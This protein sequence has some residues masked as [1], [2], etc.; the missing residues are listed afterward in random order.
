MRS[1]KSVDKIKLKLPKNF[2]A[3]KRSHQLLLRFQVSEQMDGFYR[4][5]IVSNMV[6]RN[7]SVLGYT[8]DSENILWFTYQNFNEFILWTQRCRRN[9]RIEKFSDPDHKMYRSWRPVTDGEIFSLI[10]H[11]KD[12]LPREWRDL[13]FFEIE[14]N[15]ETAI[16]MNLKSVDK[17]LESA[18]FVIFNPRSDEVLRS[19]TVLKIIGLKLQRYYHLSA[20]F[21]RVKKLSYV[22]DVTGLFNQRFLPIALDREIERALRH[23]AKFSILFLDVD[24]FKAI[25]DT[26]GHLVG[27]QVLRNIGQMIGQL[28]RISDYGFRYGGDEFLILLSGASTENSRLVAE[29]LRSQVE[30]TEFAIDG[31]KINVTVSIGVATYPEH[32]QTREKL[33]GLADV[34][35][36][37]AK[38]R[39]RNTVCVAS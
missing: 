36:Y 10:S 6:D 35:M 12:H 24:Y 7:L 11:F 9:K 16:V 31:H 27:S 17:N 2:D 30:K 33:I 38:G 4:L 5:E 29:R 34:A 14:M 39:N 18:L 32:A 20:R 26:Y 3:H 25:N 23:K 8:F 19:S 13:P 15:Q 22:D 28:I 1:K 37:Y 21:E